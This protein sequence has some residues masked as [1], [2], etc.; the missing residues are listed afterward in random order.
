MRATITARAEPVI[1]L[2]SGCIP[3]VER[4]VL[5]VN[6]DIDDIALEQCWNKSLSGRTS[7]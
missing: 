7:N 5:P 4:N 2:M 1:V 6:I 3:Q